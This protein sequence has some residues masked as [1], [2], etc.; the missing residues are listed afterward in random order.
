[1]EVLVITKYS[2]KVASSRV[3]LYSVFENNLIFPLILNYSWSKRV[4]TF[5]LIY[6]YVFIQLLAIFGNYKSIVIQKDM[7]ML[8]T[9]TLIIVNL[10]KKQIIFDIDDYFDFNNRKTKYFNC[11]TY[12]SLAIGLECNIPNSYYM[13][14]SVPRIAPS[15]LKSKKEKYILWLG[16]PY[17]SKYIDSFFNSGYI[18]TIR[19]HGY[20][21]ILIGYHGVLKN[22]KAVKILKWTNQIEK[23]YLKVSEI[24]IMPLD[25][26][27]FEYY[28][29]GYKLIKYLSYN[30]KVVASDI[31]ANKFIVKNLPKARLANNPNLFFKEILNLMNFRKN[32][33]DVLDDQFILSN[34]I[35][36]WKQIINNNN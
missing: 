31:G 14:T 19:N 36:R 24:G 25:N 16:T 7:R 21:L 2:E 15:I 11:C 30:L 22:N 13:P 23:E 33:S 32:D 34:Y 12:G 1:M 9:V 26:E 4:I 17:T 29:C 18:N 35:L 28:K 8:S 3:R 5:Q 6:R 10:R 20:K 27:S